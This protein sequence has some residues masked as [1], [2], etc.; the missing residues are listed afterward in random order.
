MTLR[1]TVGDGGQTCSVMPKPSTR[2]IQSWMSA[3]CGG[4][5]RRKEE[6]EIKALRRNVGN[7]GFGVAMVSQHTKLK[8]LV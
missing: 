3:P 7:G 1:R 6:N 4:C 8:D 2:T 5:G